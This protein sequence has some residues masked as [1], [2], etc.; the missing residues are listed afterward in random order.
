MK[1]RHNTPFDGHSAR[2]VTRD[3]PTMPNNGRNRGIAVHEEIFNVHLTP[4]PVD[5]RAEEHGR[6]SVT[7][8]HL[9]QSQVSTSSL[10]CGTQ[11]DSQR[12]NDKTF[13]GGEDEFNTLLRN[14]CRGA[15]STR[16]PR[17]NR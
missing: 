14:R 10:G 12:P 11:P 16:G 4:R 5:F 6:L 17:Q 8:E 7:I 15:C 13:G 9:V 1:M 2:L 3:C